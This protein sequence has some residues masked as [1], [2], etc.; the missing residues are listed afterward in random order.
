MLMLPASSPA[1]E[2]H[3]LRIGYA[4][5]L[6]SSESES[7]RSLWAQRAVESGAS[8]ERINVSWASI[9]PVSPPAGFDPSDPSSP[10]YTWERLD[11]AVRTVSAHGLQVLLTVQHAPAWA[12]GPGRPADF[13]PGVWKPDPGAYGAFGHALAQRYSG[14]FPDPL[15]PGSTLPR[16]RYFDAWNEP[17]LINFLAPQVSESGKLVGPAMYRRLL[18]RFYAG[19]KEAQPGATV[20]GASSASFGV[21]NGI[22]TA[23][24]L[25]LRE[26]LCLRGSRLRPVP[27]P[28]K[29]H[30]DKLSAHAIQTG[31]PAESA[32]SPLDAT[33]PDM[34]RL[35]AVLRAAEKA[36]TVRS[37]GRIGLWVT[38]FWVDSS[39]P[40]PL[41]IPLA[42]QARWYDLNLHEYWQDGAEVAI[43]LLLRDQS[44]DKEGFPLTIQSGIYFLDGKPK[45][46]QAAMRF[47]F[48]A[49]RSGARQVSTWGIAPRAGTLRIQVQRG[50]AWKTL[51]KARVAGLGHPFTADVELA[52]GGKLRAVVG[53]ERSLPW[54]LG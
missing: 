39:P 42:Q 53:S 6:L 49:Q 54:K 8:L 31:P 50:G 17:N 27:C 29:A 23:P 9:A 10:G 3:G 13:K 19:V 26:L 43:E 38:E 37:K 22:S 36:K 46:S 11:A 4:D 16:V 32:F 41:G 35:T 14:G 47:P 12:E 44:P 52:G 33:T 48:I 18:N 21:P 2:R 20:L 1:L 25:F 15:S 7:V 40:D 45:P 51:A 30:L 28:E 24:V 34:D 5:P